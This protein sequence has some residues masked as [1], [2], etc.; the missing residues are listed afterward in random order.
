MEAHDGSTYLSIGGVICTYRGQERLL[1]ELQQVRLSHALNEEMRWGKVSNRHLRGYMEWLDAFFDDPHVRYVMLSVNRSTS[2]WR[3]FR[4]QFRGSSAN[5]LALA[6]VYYQFLLVAF[7]PLR[8]TKRW[9]VYPD[10]GFFSRDSVLDRVEFLFNRTYKKAFGARSSRI[11]RLA[12][13]LD[14]KISDLIQLTDLLLAC[15]AC[16]QYH[17]RPT[18]QAKSNLLKHFVGRVA[19]STGR[20]QRGLPRCLVRAWVPQDQFN[21]SQR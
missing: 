18:S 10:A 16:T 12:R 5:D 4:A 14:S 6:S 19:A 21:Y 11:I 9:W 7:G 8:D 2:V 20:T 3:S 15:S 1:A 13:S 17:Y